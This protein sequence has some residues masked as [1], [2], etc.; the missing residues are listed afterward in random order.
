MDQGWRVDEGRVVLEGGGHVREGAG[1][2]RNFEASEQWKDGA[3]DR[4][5]GQGREG[6]WNRL[7][8]A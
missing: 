8:R 2:G 7:Q 5:I 1:E 4:G 6:E 3:E